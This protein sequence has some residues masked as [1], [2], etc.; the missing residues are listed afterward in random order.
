MKLLPWAAL[1]LAAVLALLAGGP[2]AL[3]AL[4]LALL[5]A[6]APLLALFPLHR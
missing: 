5:V 1:A 6:A 3:G 2:A 4:A